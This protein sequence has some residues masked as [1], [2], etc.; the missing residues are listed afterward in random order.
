M[1]NPLAV[2]SG[3]NMPAAMA[4]SDRPIIEH[5]SAAATQIQAAPPGQDL[6]AGGPAIPAKKTRASKR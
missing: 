2:A 6:E 4:D 5:R 1:F 3:L